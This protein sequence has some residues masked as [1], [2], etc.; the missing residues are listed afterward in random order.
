MSEI[1]KMS[2][3]IPKDFFK[4]R[5]VRNGEIIESPSELVSRSLISLITGIDC[6]LIVPSEGDDCPDYK[7]GDMGFEVTF[8]ESDQYIKQFKGIQEGSE[9][10]PVSL[11]YDEYI[12]DRIEQKAEKVR[13][14]K[15]KSVNSL[16][17]C[18]VGII[19]HID[20]Y[21]TNE[22]YSDCKFSDYLDALKIC[23]RDC[24]FDSL[25]HKYIKSGVFDNIFILQPTHREQHVCFDIK[26][27]CLSKDGITILDV[28]QPLAVPMCKTTPS[29][30]ITY[31][32]KFRGSIGGYNPKK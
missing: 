19:P 24:Y 30:G 1:A 20:W 26:K 11:D 7:V 12:E 27:H 17:L 5:K 14:G 25:Y 31:Y 29:V 6:E 21:F 32:S 22:E 4:S 16:T 15:Y 18:C 10:Y 8:A 2:I 28:N 13:A 9:P 3:Y 23:H